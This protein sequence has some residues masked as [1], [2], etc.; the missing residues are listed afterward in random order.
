MNKTMLINHQLIRVL[1]LEDR[2]HRLFFLLFTMYCSTVVPS[3]TWRN[4]CRACRQNLERRG[5]GS[6][7]VRQITCLHMNGFGVPN[8]HRQFLSMT[9]PQFRNVDILIIQKRAP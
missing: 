4:T 6:W 5:F 9:R 3:R 7:K 2:T 1:C 8:G